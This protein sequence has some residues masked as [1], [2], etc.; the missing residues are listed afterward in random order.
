MSFLD[1][2]ASLTTTPP[3]VLGYASAINAK[4]EV[5]LHRFAVAVAVCTFG[6]I[7]MGSLVTTTGSGLAVPDWPTSYGQNMFAYP[8]SKWVGGIF[9][10]HVHR[11]VAASVGFLTIVLCVWL[12]RSDHARK[13]KWL[14]TA[15]LGA[16][17]L[18]GL[19][20]GLTVLFLLPTWISVAHAGLAQIFLCV[21]VSIAVLTGPA[22]GAVA[23]RV[24]PDAKLWRLCRLV[25]GCVYAQVL[26]GALVRHTQSGLAIPDFP[27]SYGSMFPP[28]SSDALESINESRIWSE[29]QLEPVTLGQI[30]VHFVHRVGALGVAIAVVVLTRNIMS[31]Y[32]RR[33]DLVMPAWTL[34]GLLIAQIV[35]GAATIWTCRSL[36]LTTA[37][38]GAGAAMLACSMVLVLRSRRASV[39]E[40]AGGEESLLLENR[41]C[42]QVS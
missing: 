41:L 18:Q 6:L 20:G 27:L 16:V 28:T 19:L 4:A 24:N 29:P 32:S 2:N 23:A 11:L 12:W 13:L 10:E 39:F 26:L 37:H 22:R 17:C 5:G 7:L 34:C 1:G 21:I 33:T 40:P 36:P 15:A 35:L 14:G 31:R 38:V 8:P 30:W 3:A 9:Y 25:V 42:P